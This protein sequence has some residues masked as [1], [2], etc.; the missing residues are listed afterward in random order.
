MIIN[1]NGSILFKS[2][3]CSSRDFNNEL[4]RLYSFLRETIIEIDGDL[5]SGEVVYFLFNKRKKP[6]INS[7]KKNTYVI[8]KKTITIIIF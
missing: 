6:I 2:I 1:K 5:N 8:I 3:D 4:I 7:V